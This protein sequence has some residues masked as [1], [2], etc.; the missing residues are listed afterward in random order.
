M[1]VLASET[2]QNILAES[3]FFAFQDFVEKNSI[4]E[5]DAPVVN[6]PSDAEGKEDQTIDQGSNPTGTSY[7]VQLFATGSS[8]P[9][10]TWYTL[11]LI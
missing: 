2:G 11:S 9:M 5:E 6:E 7:K 4:Q 8:C 3:I 10:T 1:S